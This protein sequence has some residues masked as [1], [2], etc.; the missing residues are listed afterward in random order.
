[1]NSPRSQGARLPGELGCP[2]DCAARVGKAQYSQT[3]AA[4]EPART[5]PT[6]GRAG[7]A[8]CPLP[9]RA[10]GRRQPWLLP[11]LIVH[12]QAGCFPLGAP[13]AGPSYWGRRAL[14]QQ[15]QPCMARSP[16]R[17]PCKWVSSVRRLVACLPLP[18]K[19]PTPPS[20]LGNLKTGTSTK[21][22][23]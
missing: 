8:H 22:I 20:G 9:V 15:Q 23:W 14:S 1:M 7:A 17:K 18:V 19:A 6:E 16:E 10:P 12:M 21:A 3:R 11:L 13:R 4:L 2:G 5:V